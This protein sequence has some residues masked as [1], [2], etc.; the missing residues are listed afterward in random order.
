MK[1]VTV[2]NGR[3]YE[4]EVGNDGRLLVNGAARQVDFPAL[5]PSLYSV[6]MNNQSLPV[7]IE[8]EGGHYAVLM[9]GTSYESTVL[10]EHALMMA[11]RRGGLVTRSGEVSAPMPGLIVQVPVAVGQAV[12]EGETLVILE[13]MKMQNELQAP[14]SGTVESVH[15]SDGQTVDKGAWLAVVRPTAG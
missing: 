3:R 7:V 13:S 12:E 8:G 10:D 5:V 6:I 11:Q 1:Y 4:I 14:V 15:C 9:L 2:V